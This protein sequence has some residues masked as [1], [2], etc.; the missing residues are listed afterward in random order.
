MSLKDQMP[1]FS[2]PPPW[3][4]RTM[5][6]GFYLIAVLVLFPL[7]LCFWGHEYWPVFIFGPMIYFAIF[8]ARSQWRTAQMKQNERF[9]QESTTD[10]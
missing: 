7:G 8:V 4:H 10:A 1:F 5:A 2:D 3:Y 6:V 9:K